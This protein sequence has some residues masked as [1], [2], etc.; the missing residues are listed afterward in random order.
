VA[1]TDSK[2][3]VLSQSKENPTSAVGVS[4]LTLYPTTY[5]LELLAPAYKKFV[6]VTDVLNADGSNASNYVA[7]GQAANNNGTNLAQVVEGDVLCKLKNP[8]KDHI[9]EITYTAIDYFGWV[10]IKKYYVRF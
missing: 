2:V 1:S 9:Y 8:Q 10:S 6:A 7:L 4:E 5:T 3:S